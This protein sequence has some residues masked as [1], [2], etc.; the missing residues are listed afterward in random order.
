MAPARPAASCHLSYPLPEFL[1]RWRL[2]CSVTV[3]TSGPASYFC[4]VGWGPGSYSGIQQLEDGRRLEPRRRVGG[5]AA[6][7]GGPGLH[8]RRGGLRAEGHGGL[9]LAGG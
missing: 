5:G 7:P 8:I 3:S 1:G 9:R 2:E 6:Q 4:V